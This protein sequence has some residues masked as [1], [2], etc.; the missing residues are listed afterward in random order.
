MYRV[1]TGTTTTPGDDEEQQELGLEMHLCL[2]PQVCSFFV[3][4]LNLLMFIYYR[5][6]PL[7]LPPPP[8]QL[9]IMNDDYSNGIN[10]YNWH[11]QQ[12]TMT[13]IW[14][15]NKGRNNNNKGWCLF[16]LQVCEGLF[17]YIFI[18]LLLSSFS[19]LTVL[20]VLLSMSKKIYM[21]LFLM[22]TC[23]S[24]ILT[25]E[26]TDL[27]YVTFPLLVYLQDLNNMLDC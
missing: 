7:L 8:I 18:L 25:C 27:T 24:L 21:L 3:F 16:L 1:G 9:T 22:S 11:Q 4:Y 13:A 19:V 6:Q 17:N 2:K 15:D 5:I 12:L 26:P 23:D 14:D 20:T 10:Y